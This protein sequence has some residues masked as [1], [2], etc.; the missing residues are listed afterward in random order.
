[1]RAKS[2]DDQRI[3]LRGR[4]EDTRAGQTWTWRIKHN[5]S[6]STQGRKVSGSGGFEIR[7]ALVDLPGVDH[8]VFR[9]ER[10]RTGEVC[11]GRLE[12]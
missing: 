10:L 11:R 2:D 4:V 3:E 1:M 6:V 12:W 9:A 7:R 5:G 8:C